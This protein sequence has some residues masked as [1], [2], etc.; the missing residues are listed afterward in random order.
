[1][2]RSI[3][4][5][6]GLSCRRLFPL[7]RDGSFSHFVFNRSGFQVFGDFVQLGG[8]NSELL[9][10]FRRGGGF[11]QIA[12]LSCQLPKIIYVFHWHPPSLPDANPKYLPDGLNHVYY[13]LFIIV[14]ECF[15]IFEDGIALSSREPRILATCKRC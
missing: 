9:D 6:H 7:V 5:S 14:L 3:S 13:T 1:V 2:L 15:D 10:N 11:L 4:A 8:P 12:T